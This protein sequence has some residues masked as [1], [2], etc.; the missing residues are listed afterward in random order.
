M[1]MM[2]NT[3]IVRFWIVS[4]LNELISGEFPLLAYI[5]YAESILRML[6]ADE[7]KRLDIVNLVLF[8]FARL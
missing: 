7:Q 5:P 1:G 4:L 8:M 6:I 3:T 2:T